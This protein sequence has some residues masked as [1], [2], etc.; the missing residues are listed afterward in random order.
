MLKS[1]VTKPSERPSRGPKPIK[2][3]PSDLLDAAQTVFARDGLEDGSIR[4]IAREA[5]CDPSLL[6]YHFENKE[7]IF[8]AILER[9]FGLLLP[10]LAGIADEYTSRI[11]ILAPTSTNRNGRTPLQEA[12]WQFLMVFRNHVKDDLGFRHMIRWSVASTKKF[13]LEEIMFTYLSPAM[14]IISSTLNSGIKTGELRKDINLA[15]TTFFFVR[16]Y[17]DVLDFFPLFTGRLIQMQP[18]EAI[19]LAE[20]QWFKLFW[21]GISNTPKNLGEKL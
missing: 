12:L 2:I 17:I 19:D 6:Y 18:E 14:Q 1:A 15:M 8:L 20:V 7:A 4:A 9:K 13:G 10:G 16:T 5:G 11:K 21:A 3:D